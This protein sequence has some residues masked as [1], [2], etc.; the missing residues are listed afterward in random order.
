MDPHR[1]ENCVTLPARN[2]PANCGLA[3]SSFSRQFEK[4]PISGRKF[5]IDATEY[6]RVTQAATTSIV[7]SGL[8]KVTRSTSASRVSDFFVGVAVREPG[9]FQQ[10]SVTSGATS[11]LTDPGLNGLAE[12]RADGECTFTATSADGEVAVKTVKSRS[13]SSVSHDIFHS[14][15]DNTLAKHCIDQINSLIAG[16]TELNVFNIPGLAPGLAW[17]DYNGIPPG[18][19]TSFPR[20][21][22]CWANGIDLSCASPW[23]TD[24]GSLLAGTLVSPRH[25]AFCYHSSFYPANGKSIT[26]VSPSSVAYTR[27]VLNSSRVGD[28][29]IQIVVLDSDVPADITFAK[30][31]PANYESYLAG[32][33]WRS[34]IPVM[35]LNQ[36]ERASISALHILFP[37]FG[38]DYPLSY[39][40]YYGSL[41][42]FDS[43][44]PC[45]LVINNQPVLVGMFTSGGSGGGDFITR[46]AS[47]VNATIASLGNNPNGYQLTSVDLSGFLSI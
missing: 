18:G 10:V 31:L 6:M 43:G 38:N 22:N 34:P 20:N 35:C 14:W 17:T 46:Y 37:T 41:V 26:F 4:T 44:N 9:Y 1:Q 15:V 24:R 2:H 47:Q 16:K 28:S 45:F 21:P 3:T 8:T 25:V 5:D 11:V 29:D 42:L 12:Y 23:N 36:T 27:T 13:N 39:Q 30:V 40:S 19:P 33:N 32:L 7:T